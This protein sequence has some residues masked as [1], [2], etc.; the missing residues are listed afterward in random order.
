MILGLDFDIRGGFGA[1]GMER[2]AKVVSGFRL[3]TIFGERFVL[4]YWRSP[5]SASSYCNLLV[6]CGYLL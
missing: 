2:F 6:F 1:F 3:L 5:E 4:H